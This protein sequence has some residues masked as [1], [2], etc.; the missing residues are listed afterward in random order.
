MKYRG[1]FTFLL[2]FLKL[3]ISD[4]IDDE[5]DE[6][7]PETDESDYEIR[8]CNPYKDSK[9]LVSNEAL[10]RKVFESFSD[11][12]KY[13]TITSSRRGVRF[14]EEGLT[15]SI[16]DKFDNPALASSFYIMYGRVEVEIKG[17]SGRGIISSFYLQSDDLDEIDVV[18]IFGSDPFEFQ[19]NFFVKGNVSN[20]DRGKYHQMHPSP[21][22]GFHKYGVEWKPDLITWF[23]DDKPVR[24]LGRRNRHGMPCSP[25][26]LKFSLWSADEND[27]GTIAWAGG[28]ASFSD[29][30]FAMHI[31][32]LEVHDYSRGISYNYGHLR[33]GR[34]LDLTPEGGDIYEGHRFCTPPDDLDDTGP[35]KKKKK[36]SPSKY[37]EPVFTSTKS[38]KHGKPWEGPVS[39]TKQPSAKPTKAWDNYDEEGDQREEAPWP[40]YGRPQPE[41][42]D[43]PEGGEKDQQP[44]EEEGYEGD[45][46]PAQEKEE[47]ADGDHGDETTTVPASSLLQR[48][49]KARPTKK[50]QW[51]GEDGK[52]K[53]SR[54]VMKEKGRAK[55]AKTTTGPKT[56]GG[57]STELLT[58]LDFN[59]SVP[60]TTTAAASTSTSRARLPYNIFFQYPDRDNSIIRSGV[61]SQVSASLLTIV[62]VEGLIVMTLLL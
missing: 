17:A 55:A 18:E 11:G 3:V 37:M 5:D 8:R 36:P 7:E 29:G 27:E 35:K 1:I 59:S 20:Y 52:P 25:M 28:V 38:P 60:E 2:L 16:L 34:W 46:K 22:S 56:A 10:G 13:F 49:S 47:L 62:F 53:Q 45:K 33:N 26:F 48:S 58:T 9:C 19:T 14:D 61:S 24:M 40:E 12:T 31:K 15:L 4:E 39:A 6:S 21:L 50:F 32:N 23:L 44:E 42:N 43:Q 41:Y 51:P 57:S 54:S 30:P